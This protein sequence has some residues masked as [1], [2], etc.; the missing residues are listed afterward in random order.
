MLEKE[1]Y[2]TFVTVLVGIVIWV[3]ILSCSSGSNEEIIDAVLKHGETV[4]AATDAGT[5][6][7]EAGIGTNRTYSWNSCMKSVGLYQRRE[8]WRGSR[9]LYYP[10]PGRTWLFSCD[11]I[12]RALLEEGVLRFKNAAEFEKWL[13]EYDYLDYVYS[14]NGLMV[15]WNRDQIAGQLTVEVW[16]ILI[17]G[18]IPDALPGSDD[19]AIQS[20]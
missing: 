20:G 10:G 7:V 17:G 6:T 12:G 15:G 19:S 16:Q 14:S 13:G 18:S 2:R 11:G 8:A 3:L 5:I 4:T 1:Q 9:G